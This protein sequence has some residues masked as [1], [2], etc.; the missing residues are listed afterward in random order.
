[1]EGISCCNWLLVGESCFEIHLKLKM[2]GFLQCGRSSLGRFLKQSPRRI[3]ASAK[4][5]G[6]SENFKSTTAIPAGSAKISG[7]LRHIEK[8][9]T[10]PECYFP[11]RQR[12]ESE[13]GTFIDKIRNYVASTLINEWLLGFESKKDGDSLYME[14]DFL[15]G[16]ERAFQTTVNAIFHHKMIRAVAVLETMA[17]KSAQQQASAAAIP[18]PGTKDADSKTQP[19]PN[20]NQTTSEVSVSEEKP[21]GNEGMSPEEAAAAADALN[22]GEIFVPDLTTIF[23]RGLARF[24]EDAIEKVQKSRFQVYYKLENMG[25]AE[26][27]RSDILFGAKRGYDFTGLTRKHVLGIVGTTAAQERPS[28]STL[29]TLDD[30]SLPRH[31]RILYEMRKFATIRVWVDFP[32]TGEEI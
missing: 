25:R 7:H 21:S 20:V 9:E 1:V 24:Y 23:E 32:V 12:V 16:A 30:S 13:T 18:V 31:L 27:V 14:I 5:F 6:G 11:W 2:V 22:K 19:A 3:H 17:N 8:H 4:Y 28:L 10:T 29:S 26:I 15:L